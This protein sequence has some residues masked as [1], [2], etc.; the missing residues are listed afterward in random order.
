MADLAISFFSDSLKMKTSIKVL[1]PDHVDS[2]LSTLILFHG[3]GDDENSWME[4][5]SLLRY[6][7]NKQ[8][9]VIM[10]RV[11]LSYYTNLSSGEKYFDYVSRELMIK[12]SQWFPLKQDR[13][14]CFIAGLSMGGYGA[15][16][17]A[18]SRSEKFSRCYALSA[19][20]NIVD[21]WRQHPE[22]DSWYRSLFV[23]Q[24]ELSNSTN[25]L[26][27]LVKNWPHSNQKP[28]IWQT[29]GQ[30]DAFSQQNQ[31]F[32]NLL[33]QEDFKTTSLSIANEGHTWH[34]WDQQIQLV[35]NDI[36]N[37]L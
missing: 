35:I 28:Y 14:H 12:C 22:R 26:F 36:N 19:A 27:S 31:L 7:S 13:E 30:N 32:H 25:N 21:Q 17:V 1:L 10:P 20:T 15:L 37:Y 16:K 2:S 3:M 33:V 9:A 29:C 6:L 24:D 4:N 11:D 5:T 8:L 34:F 23:S 18:L